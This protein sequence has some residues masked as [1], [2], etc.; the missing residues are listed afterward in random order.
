METGSVSLAEIEGMAVETFSGSSE[1]PFSQS[2]TDVLEREIIHSNRVKLTDY[3]HD[4]TMLFPYMKES[5]VFSV[6]D[7]EVI[8]GR[9]CSNYRQC[10]G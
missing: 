2:N 4:P 1:D 3:I 6:Y 10:I 5:D 9:L 8:K 7:C